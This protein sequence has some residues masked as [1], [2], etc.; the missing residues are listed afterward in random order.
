MAQYDFAQAE[1]ITAGVENAHFSFCYG[2]NPKSRTL[3]AL[4]IL[5]FLSK[6]NTR[7]FRHAAVGCE[8]HQKC[9]S[10]AQDA[11]DLAELNIKYRIYSPISRPMYKPTP[12]PT[13]KNVAKN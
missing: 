12:I 2:G 3:A 11:R 8:M 10:L 6:K 13:A 7:D 4:K 1:T 9:A 5:L